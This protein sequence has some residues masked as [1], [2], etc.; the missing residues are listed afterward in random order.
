[1]PKNI[2]YAQRLISPLVLVC[3]LVLAGAVCAERES[4]RLASTAQKRPPK[5]VPSSLLTFIERR[6]QEQPGI[7]P[8]ELAAYANTI[9]A[10]EGFNYEFDACE[11]GRAG[12]HGVDAPGASEGQTYLLPMTSVKGEKITFRVASVNMEG[13]CG[14]CFFR[15]PCLK[16]T[17]RDMLMVSKGRRYSLKRSH[18]MR[19]DEMSLVDETMKRVLLTW[20]VPYQTVPLG[21]SE[22]GRKLYLNLTYRENEAKEKLVLEISETGLRIEARDALGLKKGEWIEEHP[23]DPK[24]SYLSFM[25]F[26]AGGQSYIIR[27]SGPCT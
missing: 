15:I 8:K 25:R 13:L 6:A 19:L 5:I 21:V 18:Q 23:K 12:K 2:S 27:F 11:I 3:V 7:S 20:Q 1:M 17:K 4:G 9:L 22:D 14:E 16:V 10:H 24:N 26:Q